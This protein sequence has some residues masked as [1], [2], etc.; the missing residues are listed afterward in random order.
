MSKQRIAAGGA[1][2]IPTVAEI[3]D[4][5]NTML[6]KIGQGTRFTRYV[7]T[8]LSDGAGLFTLKATPA[9]GFMWEV[10]G[11]LVDPGN[12][13]AQWQ[14]FVNNVSALGKLCNLQTG[15]V[16]VNPPSKAVILK[17][18]DTL[19]VTNTFTGG[20]AGAVSYPAGLAVYAVE[21]PFAHEAQ[22]LL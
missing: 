8:G 19:I 21:V 11:I 22:Y 7:E 17:G 18:N 4:P 6:Q 9:D 5:I 3:T 15:N 13:T 14:A 10:F 16:I 2:E 20:V 12:T 1:L